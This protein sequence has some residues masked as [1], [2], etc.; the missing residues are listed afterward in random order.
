[1]IEDFRKSL[2][3]SYVSKFKRSS[4]ATLDNVPRRRAYHQRNFLS[5]MAELGKDDPVLELGCGAGKLLK[6]LKENGYTNCRGIDVSQEQVAIAE[7]NGVSAECTDVF[8]YLE[9][10]SAAFKGII[11][12]DF[13]EHFNKNEVIRLGTLL[14]SALCENGIL[15][16]QT[17]NGKS[18]YALRNIYGDLTHLTIFS[19]ES[20]KQWLHAAGFAE[21]RVASSVPANLTLGD[22]LRGLARSL[23]LSCWRWKAFIV[24]GRMETVVGENLVAVAKRGSS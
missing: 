4:A 7:Q 1:M 18:P 13:F 17:P 3:S 12:V 23:M 20:I 5:L 19:D 14:H 6:S 21:I 16:L 24:T 15:I 8:R 11:A 10:N 22:K 9:D 2:Y